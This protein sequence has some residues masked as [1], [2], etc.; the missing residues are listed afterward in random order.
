[1][2]TGTMHTGTLIQDLMDAVERVEAMQCEEKSEIRSEFWFALPE[3]NVAQPI[4]VEV[5]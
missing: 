3:V 2:D 4:F 5:A 1:M